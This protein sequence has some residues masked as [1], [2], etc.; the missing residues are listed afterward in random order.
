MTN[1]S[2]QQDIEVYIRSITLEEIMGW[3]SSCFTYI[4]FNQQCLRNFSHGK[5]FTGFV[6]DASSNRISVFVNPNAA[7]KS[8]CSIWFQSSKTPWDD[9]I[10]C[11]ESILKTLDKEVRCSAAG[12]TDD[13]SIESE[14]WWRMDRQGKELIRWG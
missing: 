10:T 7:G 3:L 6:E 1:A 8:F 11:A 5:A 12:W 2:S 13:E 4:D 14:Q 9:D